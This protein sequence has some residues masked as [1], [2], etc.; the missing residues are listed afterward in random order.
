MHPFVLDDDETRARVARHAR[1]ED[2]DV[3][4]DEDGHL[5]LGAVARAQ[6]LEEERFQ[7]FI[8]PVGGLVVRN[9]RGV[10]GG[11]KRRDWFALDAGWR[12]VMNGCHFVKKDESVIALVNSSRVLL[13]AFRP[14]LDIFVLLLRRL[15]AN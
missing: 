7:V 15:T 9:E 11:L 13:L 12:D 8:G 3:H 6:V 10:V 14:F 2:D 4:D 1:Q 5:Q